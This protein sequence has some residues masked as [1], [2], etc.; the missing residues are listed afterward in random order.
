[1]ALERASWWHSQGGNL[2]QI[3]DPWSMDENKEVP[4]VWDNHD[5]S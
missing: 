2:P 1:M 5:N 4:S 3:F